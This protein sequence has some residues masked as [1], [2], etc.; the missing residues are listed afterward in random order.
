LDGTI[1]TEAALQALEARLLALLVAYPAGLSEHALLSLLR[2]EEPLFATFS[3]REPLSLFRGHYLLFHA[4]YRLRER[5]LRAGQG[6]VRVE[7]LRIALEACADASSALVAGVPDM[8]FWY[9]D[10]RRLATVTAA[11]VVA[12]LREFHTQ[13]LVAG[14]RAA[15]LAVLGLRDPVDAACIEGQYRRLAMRHHPD[16]GG[17]EQHAR[18]L[19]A[20]IA[21]LRRGYRRG[22]RTVDA[23]TSAGTDG[24]PR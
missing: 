13:R 24:S 19:N 8:G 7:P 4:L 5:R 17:D 18:E 10:I 14:Q 15:A 20:A 6:S 2:R 11:G 3:A 23:A 12:L 21:V 9:A 22:C 16:R 1:P